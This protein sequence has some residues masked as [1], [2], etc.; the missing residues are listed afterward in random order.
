MGFAAQFTDGIVAFN[1]CCGLCKYFN[2]WGGEADIVCVLFQVAQT[3]KSAT[4]FVIPCGCDGC[5]LEFMLVSDMCQSQL[6]CEL[7]SACY[8]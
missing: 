6:N 7:A 8:C 3:G 1:C 4:C 5:T 2:G